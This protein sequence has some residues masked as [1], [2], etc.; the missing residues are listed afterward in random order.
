MMYDKPCP[1]VII[2]SINQK[3][4]LKQITEEDLTNLRKNHPLIGFPIFFAYKETNP[5]GS[6]CDSPLYGT[7]PTVEIN[8]D[9][10]EPVY[11]EM[12]SS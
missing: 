9:T 5:D 3:Y 8:E 10:G 6:K 2:K 4:K 12:C 7:W 11:V 1:K